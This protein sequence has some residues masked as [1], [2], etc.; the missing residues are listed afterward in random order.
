[1]PHGF[2][3]GQRLDV[4]YCAAD[5]DNGHVNC[6]RCVISG[7]AFDEFLNLVGDVRNDLHGLAEVVATA[8]FFKY[9]F[10]DL[11]SGEVVGLLHARFNKTL[12]MAE[13]KVGFCAIVGDKN[14][15]VLKRRHGAGIDVEVGI[16]FY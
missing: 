4:T 1:L 14:F 13:V 3:K 10:V 9:A 15:A 6:V 5:F 16:Q 2:K 12:V 7:A 8:F 11:T